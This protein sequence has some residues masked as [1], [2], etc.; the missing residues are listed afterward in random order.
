MAN[1]SIFLKK[2][3]RLEGG[4]VNH[5]NDKG[6][7]TNKGITIHTFK[8]FYGNN[9]TCDD[10][11]NITEKEAEEIYRKNYWNPCWGDKIAC[12][13]VACIFVDWAVN[14]GVKTAIKNIQKIVG[15]TADGI[16]GNKTLSA[17]NSYNPK[18][19]FDKIKEA[20]KNFYENI[21][22]KNPSQKVFLK[23]WM[24][25]INDFSFCDSNC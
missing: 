8:S 19:L 17:I 14:S 25:R 12:T 2:V 11:K 6:G 10:L 16:M 22:A 3:L 1:I 4:Y 15:T 20:R 9:K 21:V 13:S 5:P 23:G 7:C 18:E 24:N